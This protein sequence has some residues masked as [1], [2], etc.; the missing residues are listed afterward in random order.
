MSLQVIRNGTAR[1][2]SSCGPWLDAEISTCSFDPLEFTSSCAIVFLPG[3]D[4][5]IEADRLA[6]GPR[7]YHRYW[8]VAGTLY[9]KDTGDPKR[10][11]SLV[12]QG[13]D[14]LF[15]TISKDDSL[16]GSACAAQLTRL[17][18]NKNTFVSMHGHDWAVV[19]WDIVAEEF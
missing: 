17:S 4:S 11:L 16:N 2:F 7:N 18:Y 1:T 5:R 12:W 13:H 19:D 14:D 3:T 9:I 10:L 6:R 8:K 15:N